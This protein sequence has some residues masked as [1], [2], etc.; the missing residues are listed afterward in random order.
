MER[1]RAN[2]VFDAK[3]ESE[4]ELEDGDLLRCGRSTWLR[5]TMP[6]PEL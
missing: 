3:P 1:W 4:L 2:E 5:V 6:R